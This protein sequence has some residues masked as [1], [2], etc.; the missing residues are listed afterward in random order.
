MP[1]LLEMNLQKRH[2]WQKLHQHYAN[3]APVH[4]RQFF[5]DDETR[6]AR[7]S[8]T[9]CGMLLDYSKNRVNDTT[10]KFLFELARETELPRQ[11]ES[12]FAGEKINFTENRAV[13]HTALRSGSGTPVYVDSQ[14]VIPG[15]ES[16]F[17]RMFAFAKC[18]HD[19]D[20]VGYTGKPMRDVV[21]IGIGGSDLGPKLV[22]EALAPYSNPNLRVHF[23]S[24][25]D[26]VHLHETLARLDPATTLFIVASKTFTT[27]ETL[28]NA[29]TARAWLLDASGDKAAVERHFVAVSTNA[30]AVTE[31]GIGRAQMFE[32]WDWVGGRYSLWS[33]IGLPI[34]LTLGPERFCELLAGAHDMDRH[35]RSAP[36]ESN[37]PAILALLG[38]WYGNF[39]GAATQLIAPYNQRLRLLPAYLQQLDMESNGKSVRR[40][41]ERVDY[42]TAPVIWGDTGNNAQ[43][44]YF[45]MLHQG[46]QLVPIDFI[47]AIE[48]LDALPDHR[49][50]LLANL[51]AQGEAFLR[52]KTADEVRTELD[53]NGITGE[54]AQRLLPHKVFPGNRPSNTL[55]L[56]RLD[57]ATLGALLALY[58]HKVFVQGALWGINSFDQWGVELG[59]QLAPRIEAALGDGEVRY[60]HDSSTRRLIEYVHR[61]LGNYSANGKA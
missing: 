6:A 24:N 52:G 33:A 37:M 61:R 45:Q 44:A 27:P 13:L 54:A 3:I 48:E 55:L 36:L 19:G 25:V 42:A 53:A 56:D 43:H 8:I 29:R 10:L 30:R 35:F 12:M 39:F 50:S 20:W 14:N 38:L 17:D 57:P 22:C 32:F 18:V 23:V 26:N 11:M 5:S 46:T 41:G 34:A 47:A 1:N 7:M 60:D 2:A 59:K 58:E 15:I 31:F 9:A 21:N 51:L 28:A 49:R 4:L 16:V 40:D